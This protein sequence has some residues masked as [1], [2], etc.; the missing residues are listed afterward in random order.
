MCT[1]IEPASR[2]LAAANLDPHR[3]RRW[4][5]YV[6]EL[7]RAVVDLLDP[8]AGER[9]LDLGCGDGILTRHLALRGCTVIGVDRSRAFV[10]AARDRGVR[11]F[12]VDARR[13]I[14]PELLAGS[15]DAVF[16]N[17]VLHWIPQAGQV[18]AGVHRL[19]RR[20]GRFVGELGGL[21]GAGNIA[22]VRSALHRALRRRGLDSGLYDPWYFPSAD[23]YRA[24]LAT[25]GFSV[26]HIRLFARPTPVPGTLEEWLDTFAMPF[27]H[28]LDSVTAR[29]VVAEVTAA[30]A[31]HLRTAKGSW[32][33]DYVR[34]RFRALRR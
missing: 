15:F 7:G 25:H 11:A 27:L 9:I 3:Y 8:R 14:G 4:A 28:H 31:P 2:A 20:G 21:G 16:S 34:L 26:S 12:T 29:A 1:N 23:A 17:A 33:V 22:V 13:L 24:L 5:P 6:P 10:A 18:V 30:V 32:R 19:L